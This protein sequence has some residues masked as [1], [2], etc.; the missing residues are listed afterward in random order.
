[1]HLHSEVTHAAARELCRGAWDEAAQQHPLRC[2]RVHGACRRA[3]G[4]RLGIRRHPPCPTISFEFLPPRTN[5][6]EQELWACIPR[7]TPLSP[8]SVSFN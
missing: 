3:I 4:P 7:L 8:R 6:L 2:P 1:M 5:T